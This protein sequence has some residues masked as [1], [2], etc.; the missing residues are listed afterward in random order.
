MRCLKEQGMCPRIETCHNSFYAWLSPI[1]ICSISGKHLQHKM[2]QY[3]GGI[4][5]KNIFRWSLLNTAYF[6]NTLYIA[7]LRQFTPS[8]RYGRRGVLYLCCIA[9]VKYFYDSRLKWAHFKAMK[10]Y[11]SWKHVGGIL[12]R[13]SKGETLLKT[14]PIHTN[15]ILL[16]I[17]FL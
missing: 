16:S 17:R 4:L 7:D 9:S 2:K 15:I 5:D 1:D 13:Q 11:Q 8:P 12:N 10:L 14:P 6:A 3:E